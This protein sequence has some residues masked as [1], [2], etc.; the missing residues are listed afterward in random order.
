MW[1]DLQFFLSVHDTAFDK[2]LS[3]NSGEMDAFAFERQKCNK[4]KSSQVELHFCCTIQIVDA[5]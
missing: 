4:I 5:L 1:V 3:A 2:L